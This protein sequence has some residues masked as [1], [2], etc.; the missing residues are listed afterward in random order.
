[1]TAVQRLAHP[2]VAQEDAAAE[3]AALHQCVV[4]VPMTTTVSAAGPGE[5]LRVAR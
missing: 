5:V 1:V 2:E 4:S 3:V